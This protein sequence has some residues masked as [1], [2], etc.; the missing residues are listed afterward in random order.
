MS[1]ATTPARG[2]T[3]GGNGNGGDGFAGTTQAT[4]GFGASAV[5]GGGGGG[6]AGFVLSNR[7]LTGATVSP[8]ALAW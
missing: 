2:G 6:G 3:L 1:A 5:G 7:S 8:S 4:S